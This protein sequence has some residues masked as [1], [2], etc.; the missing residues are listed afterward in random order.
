[1]TV[2][3]GKIAVVTGASSGLGRRFAFTLAAEGA[4]VVLVARRERA[5]ADLGEEIR[6]AG[7]QALVCPA[8][9]A[10]ADAIAPIFDRAEKAFGPVDILV[11]NAAVPDAD[12]ATRLSIETVDQVIAVDFRAPFLMAREMADRL[13][14]R[15]QPGRIV[16]IASVGVVHYTPRSA[17]ALYCSC[18]AAIVR[19]TETLA[20]EWAQYEINVNAISPGMVESE[21]TAGFIERVGEKVKNGF[22]RKR[23]GKPEDIDSTLLYLLDPR[24]HFVTGTCITVDD[25]QVSR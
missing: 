11:N 5:L 12:F 20:I 18:K 6:Q 2:L 25:A 3:A 7:G 21:M 19:M 13:I 22:P 8:D 24:S 15:E 1:M 23:F 4:A 17:S 10:D 9:L 16:N 14:R